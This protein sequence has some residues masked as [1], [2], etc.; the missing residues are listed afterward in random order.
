MELKPKEKAL[1][2]RNII[3]IYTIKKQGK[4]DYR[5]HAKWLRGHWSTILDFPQGKSIPEW[6]HYYAPIP[7]GVIYHD[8]LGLALEYVY[9]FTC[10]KGFPYL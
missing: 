1:R 5:A 9:T 3:V 6:N 4:E 10:C 7:I 2:F 8:W